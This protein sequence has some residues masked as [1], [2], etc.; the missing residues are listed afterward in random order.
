M[1]E[2]AERLADTEREIVKITLQEGELHKRL[3]LLLLYRT[4]LVR[5]ERVTKKHSEPKPLRSGQYV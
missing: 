5:L 3:R 1:N 2:Y 4:R